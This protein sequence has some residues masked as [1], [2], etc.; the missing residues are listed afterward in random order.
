LNRLVR[1]LRGF[2]AITLALG[3][4]AVTAV[5]FS[6]LPGAWKNWR[7]SRA[8]EIAPTDAPRLVEAT[9]A[10]EVF[11][12]SKPS[13]EDLRIIDEQGNETPYTIFTLDGGKKIERLAAMVHEKSFTPGEYTQAVIEIT[14]NAPFHNSLEI[15]TAEQNF[16]EWVSVEASDDARKWRI[17]EERAPIFRF[18]KDGREGTRVVHYSE[19]NGRYLRVRI[20][21]G[22]KQ[23]PISGAAVFHETSAPEE[24]V[25]IDGVRITLDPHPPQRQSVWIADLGG[26]GLPVSE[27][28]FDVAPMEFVRSVNVAASDD[29][30]EWSTFAFGQVYRFHQG[31]KVQ[32]QLTVPIA[33][34]GTGRRY[35]RVTVENGNDA[36]LAS[37]SVRLYT[38]PRHIV[39]EQQPGKS[40]SL[41]YGQERAQ[42]AQYDL[43]RRVNGTQERAAIP[44]KLGP[45]EVNTGWVDP[46]PWTETHEIFLWGVLVI[47]VLVIGFTAIQSMRRAA[48]NTEA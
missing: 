43:G 17:V 32:E 13:L 47:A 37:A 19:N 24:R 36:P 29:Q 12:R 34:G 21:D 16:I 2:A 35:W 10:D 23:F 14:G 27:V 6:A 30:K 33:Y 38:T 18:V 8:I 45:E 22:D 7:Y 40:Y 42:F 39:F 4:C 25:P 5:A 46:R 48:S 1:G 3:L 26:A 31:D 9:V 44:G 11:L 15:E 41:I 28:R 20:F